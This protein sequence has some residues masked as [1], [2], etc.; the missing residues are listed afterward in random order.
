MLITVVRICDWYYADIID[1]T[2]IK[3]ATVNE[4]GVVTEVLNTNVVS[5]GN[6]IIEP[7]IGSIRRISQFSLY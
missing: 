6:G 1:N 2:S 7:V 3:A 4:K 5:I